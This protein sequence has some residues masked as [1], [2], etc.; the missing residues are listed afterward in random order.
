MHTVVTGELQH[1]R[2][3]RDLIQYHLIQFMSPFEAKR[4]VGLD[5]ASQFETVE[6]HAQ[7]R[8][9]DVPAAKTFPG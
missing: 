2:F 7:Q 4:T 1:C 9:T 8:A 6:Y 5:R 3:V